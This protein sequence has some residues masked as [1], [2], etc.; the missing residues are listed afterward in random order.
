VNQRAQ[1]AY[2]P[3]ASREL[4]YVSLPLS[5]LARG[6]R[7][8]DSEAYLSGG[9]AIRVQIE[10]S[11]PH[12]LL[13]NMAD[14]WQPSRL[15]GTLVSS[16]HGLPFLTATQVF[17]VRP[18]ARKFIAP[19]RTPELA[20][21]FVD[22]GWILV[23]RSGSVGDTIISYSPHARVVVSDDVLRVQP[24]QE[25]ERAYLYAFLRTRPGLTM[26]RSP[27]Y[28]SIVKHLEPE[29]LFDIPVPTAS[30]SVYGQI[31]RQVARVFQLRDEAF[32]LTLAAEATFAARF[33]DVRRDF[34]ETGYSVPASEL[35]TGRRRLD[36]YHHNLAAKAVLA[37]LKTSGNEVVPLSSVA[38][39]IF[40]VPRFKHV[41]Q[42]KGI[43]Y[44]DSEDLFKINPELRKFIPEVTKKDAA[45]YYVERGWLL[46][47]S[48]GQLYGLN[49]SVVLADTWHEG[50]I[51]SNHV[52][53]IVPIGVRPGYLAVALG[54]P[55]FGRPLMLRL[56]FGSEVPEIAP[57]DLAGFPVV[58]LPS[59]VEDEIAE[60][61]ERASS[62]RMEA[63]QQENAAVQSLET[64]VERRLGGR[65][66]SEG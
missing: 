33:G 22:P 64:D 9:Y 57:E 15:K 8:L 60:K 3:D 66:R 23:T 48:S 45:K 11:L 35:S 2:L 10:S 36:G 26:L 43:P 17:D 56:A 32:R 37:A 1:A 39:P 59:A 40:G 12:K 38:N 28:G 19:R 61:M 16:E 65:T 21:R 58:R 52:I 63:D 31:D 49:G 24:K 30:Q 53:R 50:K 20:K 47:A 44:L 6:E 7:R 14:V 51:V 4:E 18:S 34:E 29:H 54:H 41:Y 46:M 27:R 13:T 62:L 42:D 5:V 55:A 25:A